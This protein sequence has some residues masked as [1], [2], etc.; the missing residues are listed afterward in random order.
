VYGY[1]D[2]YIMEMIWR[3]KRRAFVCKMG[4]VKKNKNKNNNNNKAKSTNNNN[5]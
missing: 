4:G 5:K 1:Y 2:V 3:E